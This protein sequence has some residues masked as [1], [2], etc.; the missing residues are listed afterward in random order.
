MNTDR[1]LR[2]RIL[3]ILER[4]PSLGAEAIAVSVHD[5]VVG[6]YGHAETPEQALRAE[7]LI[8]EVPGVRALTSE[9]EVAAGANPA[10]FGDY[11]LARAIRNDFRQ[12]AYLGFDRI[13]VKVKDRSVTLEGE[14]NWRY[15]ARLAEQHVLRVSGAREIVNLLQARD[16]LG[17]DIVTGTVGRVAV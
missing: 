4:D 9:I 12:R 17:V 14:L 6:L 5:E 1:K 11:D 16:E 15:Q 7:R 2:Q 3:A 8:A 13:F 10:E